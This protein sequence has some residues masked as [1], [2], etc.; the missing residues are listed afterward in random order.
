MLRLILFLSFTFLFS[1]QVFSQDDTKHRIDTMLD[2]CLS[3]TENMSTMGMVEC[4][5]KA[6]KE[7]D[8]EMNRVYN[9]LKQILP[10]DDFEKLQS[11][12][13]EWIKYKD[14]EI[15]AINSIY[16]KMDGTMYIPMNVSAIME[17]TRARTIQLQSYL[18]L[19]E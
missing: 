10:A 12:Q 14:L 19:F 6:A 16:S 11:S 5:D 17:L 15:E 9:K 13:R 3:I 18:F 1:S 2:S 4:T 7:W 8:K